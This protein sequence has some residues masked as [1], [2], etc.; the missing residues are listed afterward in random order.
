MQFAVTI[1]RDDRDQYGVGAL[2]VRELERL[3]RELGVGVGMACPG[4]GGRRS[5]ELHL[6]AVECELGK[7]EPF[8]RAFDARESQVSKARRAITAFLAG[9]PVNENA[10]LI[11]SELVTNSILHSRSRDGGECMLRAERLDGF[12]WLEVEDAGGPW[13]RVRDDRE[14]GHGLDIVGALCG[15]DPA[16]LPNMGMVNLPFGGRVVWVRVP[17]R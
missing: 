7:R 8:Q 5:A 10:E 6:A 12:V 9:S 11:V 17:V 3:R 13:K 15:K 14:G 4:T 1:C 2:S 16:G